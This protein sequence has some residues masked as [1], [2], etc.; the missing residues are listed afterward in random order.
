MTLAMMLYQWAE[1]AGYNNY[2]QTTRYVMAVV[3]TR[4]KQGAW[5]KVRYEIMSGWKSGD[6]RW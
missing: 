4:M 3:M 1:C 2:N 5:R 6:N